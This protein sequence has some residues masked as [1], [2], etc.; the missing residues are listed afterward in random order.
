MS[1]PDPEQ[2]VECVETHSIANPN[3]GPPALHQRGER[4]RIGEIEHYDE[5]YWAP[6]GSSREIR[7]RR[8]ALEA[9][10]W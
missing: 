2:T 5:A 7:D 9:R 3:G 10:I 6:D 8:A 4:A 1:K